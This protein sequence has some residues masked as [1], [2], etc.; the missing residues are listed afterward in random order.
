MIFH[1]SDYFEIINKAA[2]WGNLNIPAFSVYLLQIPEKYVI[3]LSD[4]KFSEDNEWR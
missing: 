4:K 3:I 2:L 1:I